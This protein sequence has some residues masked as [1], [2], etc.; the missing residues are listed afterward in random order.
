[1]TR[2]LWPRCMVSGMR[3]NLISMAWWPP[4][5]RRHKAVIRLAAWLVPISIIIIIIIR[6]HMPPLAVAH[7]RC[8]R[9]ICHITW[10]IIPIMGITRMSIRIS[11]CIHMPLPPPPQLPLENS[12][13]RL[14]IAPVWDFR[15]PRQPR[16]C[17]HLLRCRPYLPALAVTQTSCQLPR[18][19]LASRQSKSPEHPQPP[20]MWPMSSEFNCNG[21][22]PTPICQGLLF[23]MGRGSSLRTG[24]PLRTSQASCCISISLRPPGVIL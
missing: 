22:W 11:C 7:M 2:I 21:K 15:H 23:H 17:P 16:R 14:R 10:R 9:S 3:T 24:R 4:A 6:I 1:M 12:H 5:R 20:P 8:P 13:R 19:A 18:R